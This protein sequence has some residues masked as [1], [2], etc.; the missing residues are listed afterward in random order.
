M[1]ESKGDKHI[2]ERPPLEDEDPLDSKYMKTLAE[3][4]DHEGILQFAVL[5]AKELPALD[6]GGTSDPYFIIKYGKALPKSTVR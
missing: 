5:E 2:E 1:R 6:R 3:D 4:A